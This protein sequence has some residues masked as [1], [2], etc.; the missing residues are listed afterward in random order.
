MA[1]VLGASCGD[2][3]KDANTVK[4]DTLRTVKPVIDTTKKEVFTSLPSDILM[5]YLPSP[6]GF[7]IK[8]KP[9]GE[10]AHRGKSGNIYFSYAK[11]HYVRGNNDYYIEIVD[12]KDKPDV[13]Q[14]LLRMYGFDTAINNNEFSTSLEKIG[15]EKVR[16]LTTTYKTE[17]TA[18][19]TLAVNNRFI[20]NG[21]VSGST[22]I[23]ALKK[24]MNDIKL[25]ELVKL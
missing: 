19:L 18:K 2:G 15:V 4:N 17:K 13:L 10:S 23:K 25:D 21:N 5:T 16:A 20:I 1:I 6:K 12:Y 9:S 11:Q 14:G 22:D 24:L 3:N 8:G 7:A